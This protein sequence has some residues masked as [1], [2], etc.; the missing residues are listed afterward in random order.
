MGGQKALQQTNKRTNNKRTPHTFI[1]PRQDS[2]N[3]RANKVE[4]TKKRTNDHIYRNLISS[5]FQR[6]HGGGSVTTTKKQTTNE[7]NRQS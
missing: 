4:R 6:N 5:T 2:Q 1:R 3:H 7:H